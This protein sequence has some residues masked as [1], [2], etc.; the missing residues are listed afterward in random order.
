MCPIGFQEASRRK[1][2]YT[3][4]DLGAEIASQ[5]LTYWI[6]HRS[7]SATRWT[8]WSSHLISRQDGSQCMGSIVC[9]Q[10]KDFWGAS[11][12]QPTTSAHLIPN[13]QRGKMADIKKASDQQ[14][15]KHS[16]DYVYICFIA[17]SCKHAM[18]QY[19]MSCIKSP[20]EVTKPHPAA[21]R[22]NHVHRSNVFKTLRIRRK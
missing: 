1:A 20:K 13:N 14:T 17:C 16:W 2:E 3:A 8:H 19:F 21:S 9:R 4:R 15:W 10:V 18:R 5:N 22:Q 6:D 12:Q 11:W 7:Y